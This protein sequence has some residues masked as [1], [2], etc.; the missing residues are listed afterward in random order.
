MYSKL[1]LVLRGL[2]GFKFGYRFLNLGPLIDVLT[3][4]LAR[5]CGCWMARYRY[6]SSL[7]EV[8]EICLAVSIDLASFVGGLCNQTC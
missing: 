2:N 1:N 6:V 7:G 3:S 5:E 4:E 8:L